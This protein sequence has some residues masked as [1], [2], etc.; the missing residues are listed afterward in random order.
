[1][2]SSPCH[3]TTAADIPPVLESPNT[4]ALNN[5]SGANGIV[6]G[7]SVANITLLNLPAVDVNWD[8]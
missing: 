1:M 2:S 3:I 7:F 4:I 8:G 5:I 6:D